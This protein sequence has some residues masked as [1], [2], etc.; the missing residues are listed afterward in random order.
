MFQVAV[1]EGVVE[2][3]SLLDVDHEPEVRVGLNEQFLPFEQRDDVALLRRRL[4]QVAHQLESAVQDLGIPRLLRV[5]DQEHIGVLD[6]A[7]TVIEDVVDRGLARRDTKMRKT[8]WI[9]L[10]GPMLQTQ[11]EHAHR[12]D[13]AESTRPFGSGEPATLPLREQ[14]QEVDDAGGPGRFRI[15]RRLSVDFLEAVREVA[16]FG[17]PRLD[18]QVEDV[19]EGRQAFVLL[20]HGAAEDVPVIGQHSLDQFNHHGDS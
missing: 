12:V 8:D 7:E 5:V 14:A 13:L 19:E 2:V 9:A 18:E 3:A 11:G 6:F 20:A 4:A 15:H 17:P 16:C 1:Q 10:I